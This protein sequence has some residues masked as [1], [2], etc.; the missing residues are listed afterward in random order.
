MLKW[1]ITDDANS[2]EA[3]SRPSYPCNGAAVSALCSSFVSALAIITTM[4]GIKQINAAPDVNLKP[5]T[6]FDRHTT[7]RAALT[8]LQSKTGRTVPDASPNTS[9][10]KMG[11][12]S[13]MTRCMLVIARNSTQAVTTWKMRFPLFPR[14]FCNTS[15]KLLALTSRPTRTR[16]TI[17]M[18]EV[19][20]RMINKQVQARGPQMAYAYGNVN[21][22]DPIAVAV[23][24]RMLEVTVPRRWSA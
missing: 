2:G 19:M 7:R 6:V 17:V 8:T 11:S 3:T 4:K 13:A 14:T 16:F 22:P 20:A 5:C 9:S 23:R 18:S 10:M 1:H 24:F 21:K 15:L 12:R